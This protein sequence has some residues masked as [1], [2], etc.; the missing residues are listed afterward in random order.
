MNDFSQML[1]MAKYQF[2]N[3]LRAK[4]LYILLLI[5]ALVIALIV[6]VH[7]YYGN[8]SE[9]TLKGTASDFASFASTLV[10]LTALFFGGDAIAAE[11]QNKTGYFLLP[12]PI[13]RYV[14]FWGKYI[15][16]FLAS[17]IILLLY[18]FSGA[19]YT[20]YF[21]QQIP[22][23]YYYSV[24][25][26]FVFLLSLLAFTYLFSTFF[27]NGAVAL[28]IV[29]ILYFFV[30]NIID[31]V[32]QIANI[33]PWFSITYA[34]NIITLVF[35]GDYIGDYPHSKVLHAGRGITITTYNPYIYEG[36]AIMLAYLLISAILAT[37]IFKWK[38]LK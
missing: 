15:A 17:T 11:Y 25:Y 7:A 35:S 10:V 37:L 31:G 28:T 3:Y 22:V 23:E 18:F 29:A 1:V 33:E 14:V 32:S 21:H 30:F 2:K 5:T 4:R 9:D 6:F 26:S 27:K 16:S 8:P 24:L 19:V 12:N 38:E 13:K 36:I 20:Y 34:A